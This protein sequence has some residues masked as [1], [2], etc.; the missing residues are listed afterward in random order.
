MPQVHFV[1]TREL[2][3]KTARDKILQAPDDASAIV[4]G[5]L[6]V[7]ALLYAFVRSWF[8]HRGALEAANLRFHQ[9]MCIAR[10]LRRKLKREEWLWA[11][12]DQLNRIRNRL[13]H[14]IHVQDFPVS[15]QQLYAA[16]G[17]HIDIHARGADSIKRED[18]KLKFFLLILCGVVHSLQREKTGNVSR[19]R[20]LM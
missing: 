12:L 11:T 19:N 1:A 20:Y 15:L 18:Y 5:H 8:P 7:E 9:T 10:A 13:S 3:L 2:A 17:P 14:D 6:V 4:S 16:A